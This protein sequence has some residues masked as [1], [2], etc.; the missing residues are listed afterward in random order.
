[1]HNFAFCRVLFVCFCKKNTTIP[2]HSVEVKIKGKKRFSGFAG[3]ESD[4]FSVLI[5]SE[6]AQAY[7]FT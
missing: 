3:L 6:T 5:L 1:L 2:P 4:G 7:M